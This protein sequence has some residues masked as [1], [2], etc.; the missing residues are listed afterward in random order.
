MSIAGMWLTGDSEA[1]KGWQ[2]EALGGSCWVAGAWDSG[3]GSCQAANHDQDWR[4]D[5]IPE[6]NWKDN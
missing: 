3:L 4:G 1:H 5:Q 6:Q 2:V